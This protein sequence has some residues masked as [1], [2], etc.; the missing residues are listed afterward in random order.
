MHPLEH[1]IY[2]S[3]VLIHWVVAS[4]PIHVFF[5]MQW[6]TLGAVTSHA[7][8]EGLMV[9]GKRRLALGSFHHQLHHRY[10]ECNYGNTEMPW[11]LWFGSFHD[12]TPEATRR[13]RE[14][15]K[16]ARRSARGS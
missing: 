4:H 15:L 13:L 14:R 2:L 5:H 8:F 16:T 6:L 12:G 7:G 1:V 10:F 3:S 9:G 11:D